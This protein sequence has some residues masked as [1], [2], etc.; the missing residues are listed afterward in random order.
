MASRPKYPH[1]DLFISG[2]T[3]VFGGTMPIFR[4]IADPVTNLWTRLLVPCNI[5]G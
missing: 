2:A 3:Y 5:R 1:D 4:T